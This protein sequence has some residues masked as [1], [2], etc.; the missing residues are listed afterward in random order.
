MEKKK[1]VGQ[2]KLM[3]KENR[4]ENTTRDRRIKVLASGIN[5]ST[6]KKNLYDSSPLPFLEHLF[7]CV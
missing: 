1:G 4:T 3:N 6:K 7:A 5:L 2:L